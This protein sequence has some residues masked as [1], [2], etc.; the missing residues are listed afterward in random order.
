MP[1]PEPP[2]APADVAPGFA[3]VVLDNLSRRFPFAAHHVASAADDLP[4]PAALHPAFHT[5]YDWHSCVH[6][7]SLGVSLLGFG[8]DPG[9]D[10][11][12]REAI[13]RNLTPGK[14]LVEARYLRD[15]PGWER[16]YGW[17]WLARLA[18]EC[19]ASPDADARRWALALDP[20]VEALGDLVSDWLARA[21][22][23]VRHGVHTNSA[24]GLGMALDAFTSL[25]RDEEARACTT[26]ALDWYGGDRDWPERWEL[27]GQDFLSAGL[28]SADL[29]RRVLGPA[30][31]AAWF[32]ALMPGLS[33][34]SRILQPV[35]VS[36]ETDGSM[37][38][39]HGLNL[40]RAGQAARIAATL[41]AA[42]SPHA[43]AA[44]RAAVRPLLAAGL[45]AVVSTEFASSHWLATFAWD[46]IG[47]AVTLEAAG[48]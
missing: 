3:D 2:P 46:A 41:E 17:A 8:L 12:L 11:A 20:A 21:Q 44:L 38:H 45:P 27:S 48:A 30:E 15:N 26:A 13:G 1:F 7:H 16:P 43:A 22:W 37:V 4:S 9:R 14:L 28:S 24:F 19:A 32:S 18:A 36:D 25:G 6:M 33:E 34:G 10:A 29:M 39:L 40:S 35:G 42:G 5:A 47:S 31:F 23:P